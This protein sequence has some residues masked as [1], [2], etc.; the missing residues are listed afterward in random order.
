[1]TF[2]FSV[3]EVIRFVKGSFG[4]VSGVKPDRRGSRE[5]EE[6]QYGP[7]LQGILL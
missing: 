5:A 4:G 1:M 7:L 6:R 3:A 2:T